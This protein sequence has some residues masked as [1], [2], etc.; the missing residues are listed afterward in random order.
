METASRP[1]RFCISADKLPHACKRRFG[2]LNDPRL[3]VEGFKRC[4]LEIDCRRQSAR[5]LL[6]DVFTNHIVGDGTR[7]DGE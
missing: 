1:K 5:F 4:R 3:E 7:A 6:V 2:A